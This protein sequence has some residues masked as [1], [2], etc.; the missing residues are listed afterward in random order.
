MLSGNN[1]N[2]RYADSWNHTFIFYVYRNN[3]NVASVEVV[4]SNGDIVILDNWNNDYSYA[5][6]KRETGIMYYEVRTYDSYH[7][8][9]AIETGGSF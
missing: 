6:Y 8:L 3:K 2:I 1:V 7:N 4:L 5:T 9:I